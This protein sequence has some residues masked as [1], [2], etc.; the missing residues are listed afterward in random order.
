MLPSDLLLL[1]REEM[2][3]KAK[4][5]LWSDEFVIGAIDDVVVGDDSAIRDSSDGYKF[6]PN[7]RCLKVKACVPV[8]RR[9]I[10]RRRR[11]ACC[12][13]PAMALRARA[14]PGWSCG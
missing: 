6:G 13:V 1:F 9:N 12:P 4:P 5:Y 2:A 7:L 14:G 10:R 3:D 11:I 8:H